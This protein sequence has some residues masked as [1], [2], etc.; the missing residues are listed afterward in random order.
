MAKEKLECR[1]TSSS[2]VAL[3]LTQRAIQ[4]VLDT[5]AVQGAQKQPMVQSAEE[6]SMYVQNAMA[7]MGFKNMSLSFD[8]SLKPVQVKV[9]T[10]TRLPMMAMRRTIFLAILSQSALHLIIH[11]FSMLGAASLISQCM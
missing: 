6:V 4:S 5:T 11:A 8:S 9:I 2:W 3:L 1:I 7:C 10:R